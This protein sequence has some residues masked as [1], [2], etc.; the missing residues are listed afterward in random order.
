MVEQEARFARREHG[1]AGVDV[2]APCVDA[3]PGV[4]PQLAQALPAGIG[5]ARLECLLMWATSAGQG[6]VVVAAVAPAAAPAGI[7]PAAAAGLAT[8]VA[9]LAG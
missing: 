9:A 8:I 1:V 5:A 3:A 2:L 6:P 7:A 4:V